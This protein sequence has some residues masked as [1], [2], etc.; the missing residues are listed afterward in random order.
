MADINSQLLDIRHRKQKRIKGKVVQR[1]DDNYIIDGDILTLDEAVQRLGEVAPAKS[2]FDYESVAFF[3]MEPYSSHVIKTY[4]VS[5]KS[6]HSNLIELMRRKKHYLWYGQVSKKG[7]KLVVQPPLVIDFD[8]VPD[9][10]YSVQCKAPVEPEKPKV[11]DPQKWDRGLSCPFCGVTVSSTPGRTLHV[12]YHHAERLDEY[13]GLLNDAPPVKSKPEQKIE[14]DEDD[15][16]SLLAE[17]NSSSELKCPFCGHAVS[18]TPG[19]TNHVKGKHP[20]RLD[21]YKKMFQ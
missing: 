14:E 17:S 11:I 9:V 10:A 21:E 20:D 4:R 7:D 12:K 19:R 15:V 18:S 2:G 3:E 13:F 5:N 16:V 8:S 1:V 6:E